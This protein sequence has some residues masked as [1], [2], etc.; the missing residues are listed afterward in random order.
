M[1][2]NA[3]VKAVEGKTVAMAAPPE[4][5]ERFE[6]TE[7]SDDD[8][9][10]LTAERGMWVPTD[11][12]GDKGIVCSRAIRGILLREETIQAQRPF[13]AF[14]FMLTDKCTC[15]D[16]EGETKTYNVGDY[17]MAPVTGLMEDYADFADERNENLVELFI[18]FEK[19]KT[20][21]SNPGQSYKVYTV[22]R[23]RK[24]YS[25]QELIGLPAKQDAPA[26]EAASAN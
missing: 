17:V 21:K 24:M 14:I 13:Q 26:L 20:S 6:P 3:A 19:L 8:S 1:S 2:K 18:R 12:T 25:R 11:D 22:K 4:V 9:I 7:P 10:V 23:L 15:L 5:A 16:P